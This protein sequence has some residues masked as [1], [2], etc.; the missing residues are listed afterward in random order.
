MGWLTRPRNDTFDLEHGSPG[1]H[2]PEAKEAVR[3][4]TTKK[5]GSPL[6]RSPCLGLSFAGTG[7]RS[8]LLPV[9]EKVIYGSVKGGFHALLHDAHYLL[10][11]NGL[12]LLLVFLLFLFLT[13][14][15]VANSH[16]ILTSLVILTSGISIASASANRSAFRASYARS[17]FLRAEWRICSGE[18][19]SRY[20]VS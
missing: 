14:G 17:I 4:P 12:L 3:R 2:R 7:F 1:C 13:V 18:Y 6:R 16:L 11:K 10:F 9:F 5:C 20:M 15:G 8:F 19:P